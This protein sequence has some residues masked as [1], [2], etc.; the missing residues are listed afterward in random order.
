M[1]DYN[2]I[3]VGI[4]TLIGLALAIIIVGGLIATVAN[5]PH[6]DPQGE[7]CHTV[8]AQGEYHLMCQ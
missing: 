7:R 3:L 1:I 8:Y 2:R 6:Y 5:P 4:C